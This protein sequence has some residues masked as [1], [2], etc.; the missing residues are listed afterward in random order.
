MIG[1]LTPSIE[2]LD[3]GISNARNAQLQLREQLVQLETQLTDINSE[4][5]DVVDLDP[6]VMKL[7][8]SKKKVI[9]INSMLQVCGCIIC[10]RC[11]N[12]FFNTIEMNTSILYYPSYAFLKIF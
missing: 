10:A 7:L 2:Q 3:Q 4:L 6:Y 11:I 12:T 9:V 8:E 1:L 5:E